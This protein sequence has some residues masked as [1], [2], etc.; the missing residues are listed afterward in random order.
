MGRDRVSIF[1]CIFE[2]PAQMMDIINH[3]VAKYIIV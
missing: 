1:W 3:W 2:Q